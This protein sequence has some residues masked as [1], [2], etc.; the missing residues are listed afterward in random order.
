MS[1]F[2]SFQVGKFNIKNRILVCPS[3]N[4]QADVRGVV[5]QSLFENL[6]RLAKQG[7]G[8]III[9]STYVCKQG[10]G[11]NMQLG[12]SEEEHVP[13]L[14]NMVRILKEDGAFIGLRLSHAGA[15]T[16]TNI[17][18]ETPIGPSIHNLGKDFDACREFDEHDANEIC[19]FFGH[20]AERAQEA[21]IDFIEINASQ[22]SLLEQT[23]SP[24]FNLRYD[25]YGGD[26]KNRM[27][28][29][30]SIIK[31][32]KRRVGSELLLSFFFK[33]LLERD[34]FLSS[35]PDLKKLLKILVAEKVDFIHPDLAHVLI[36]PTE[37]DEHDEPVLNTV[38]KNSQIDLIVEGNIK[39]TPV[40]KEVLG[41]NL[42]TFYC[43]D[44]SLYMRQNWYQFLQKKISS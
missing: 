15:R 39:S 17:C 37:D 21:D 30:V 14:R 43:L 34:G 5:S 18:G 32:I 2:D 31:E 11:H 26:I 25:E 29:A 28:L 16:N 36:K 23:I 33:N 1:L 38:A 12:I 27:S 4:H 22:G 20:A 13:G 8:A 35:L 7:A 6:L 3:S 24:A 10:R 9:D 19:T 44:K 40:L 41:S 42:G